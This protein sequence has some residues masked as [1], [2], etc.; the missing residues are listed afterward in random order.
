VTYDPTVPGAAQRIADTQAPIQTNFSQANTIFNE[1]H[2]TFNDASGAPPPPGLRGFHRKVTLN[3]EAAAP[4]AYA[5][6][7]TIYTADNGGRTDLFYR[8]DTGTLGNSKILP[9]SA[10]KV[11]AA[12][13]A[14]AADGVLAGADIYQAYNIASIT[15]TSGGGSF[16]FSVMFADSLDSNPPNTALDYVVLMGQGV[17]S[18]IPQNP[19]YQSPTRN[20]RILFISRTDITRLS[21]SILTL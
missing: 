5:D 8:Y 11:M 18:V 14:G 21:F 1:D 4:T 17:A 20:D 19:A 15:K 7:G 6:I 2:Y 12:F 13:N 9:L 16:F 10:I 3:E